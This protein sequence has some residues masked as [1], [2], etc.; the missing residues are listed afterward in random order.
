MHLILACEV[1]RVPPTAVATEAADS[2]SAGDSA[3]PEV[4][5]PVEPLGTLALYRRASLDLRGTLPTVDEVSALSTDPSLLEGMLDALLVDERLEERLVDLFAERWNMRLDALYLSSERFGFRDD[6]EFAYLR[7]VEEE[8]LR[9]MARVAVSDAPWTE[10]VTADWTLLDERLAQIWPTDREVGKGWQLASYTDGRPANGVLSTNGMWWRYHTT[11]NNYNR[12]RAAAVSRLLLC[13]DYL[14]RPIRFEPASLLERDDL[15][16]ATRDEPTC[17]GCHSTLDPLASALFGFW[18]ND[19]FLIDEHTY[20]HPDREFVGEYYLGVEPGWFGTP[21][22]AAADLGPM[23]A[24]DDRFVTCAVE[25]MAEALW[26]RDVEAAADFAAI[27]EL[28]GKFETGGLRLRSLLDAILD[29][30]E[31]RAGGLSDE[32]SDADAARYQTARLVPLQ[33]L[34]SAIADLTGFSWSR[35]GWDQLDNDNHGYRTLAGDVDGDSITRAGTDP[36]VSRAL[37]LRR[38]AQA[39]ALTVVADDLD[40]RAGSRRLLELVSV[41][42]RPEDD[43]F[44]HEL[45]RLHLRLYAAVPDAARLAADAALWSAVYAETGDPEQA[46]ASLIAAMMRDPAFW[47]Y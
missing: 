18:N 12:S 43:A 36:T 25:T 1:E 45:E 21:L 30:A 40:P 11:P 14:E 44:T 5:L 41:S 28:R 27:D 17:V 47:T 33:A 9:L 6:E 34:N 26:R 3:Q 2:A 37:V 35:E 7:A 19:L 42:T 20:Y 23:L 4:P 46:W 10:I 13:Q 29:T 31:Y 16:D 24:S 22:T 8:P 32:A 38:L 15:L 39:A